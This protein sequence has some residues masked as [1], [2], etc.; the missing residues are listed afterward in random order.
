MENY[1]LILEKMLEEIKSSKNRPSLLLHSCCGPCESY[2]LL[3]LCDYFDIT[4]DYFNPN[5]APDTEYY[6]R[7]AEAKRVSEILPLGNKVNF[8]EN[9]LDAQVFYT[10]V[11][12]LE[13]IPEGGERCFACYRL[14]MEKAAKR[15]KEQG[16]DY[17]TTTL[18][19]S[20][21]K[22]SAKLNE[23]GFALE[24][25]YNVKYLPADFKKKNGYKRSLELSKEYGLYRQS[26][27]GCAFSLAESQGR[28]A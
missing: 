17:F 7:M 5:I 16:Y 27:C 19:I 20:P 6:R 18:S 25:E 14:R 1:Q 23:I 9:A 13:D 10:A 15:A 22:N 12:G 11:N 28:R 3:Y 24:Q 8:I 21:H 26:Y 2:V 4:V